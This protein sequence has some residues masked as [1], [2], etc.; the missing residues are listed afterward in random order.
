MSRS[1]R[2][3]MEAHPDIGPMVWHFYP[4]YRDHMN[5]TGQAYPDYDPRSMGFQIIGM[6]RQ[7]EHYAAGLMQL[8]EGAMPKNQ[9]TINVMSPFKDAKTPSNYALFAHPP[10][11]D[12][13][14]NNMQLRSDVAVR[15]S[16]DSLPNIKIVDIRST[17]RKV[18]SDLKDDS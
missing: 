12:Q 6:V 2:P 1:S 9:V 13:I 8:A 18:P 14:Q 11:S 16:W 10:L 7:G 4:S 5:A 3:R 15:V 17:V